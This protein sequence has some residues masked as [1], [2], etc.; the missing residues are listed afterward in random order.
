VK[1]LRRSF[2]AR[3]GGGIF[4]LIGTMLL[5]TGCT[6]PLWWHDPERGFIYHGWSVNIA[7][8]ATVVRQCAGAPNALGCVIP[9]TMTA[10]S[11]NNPYVL[12]HECAHIRNL[13]AG[14]GAGESIKDTA[15]ML[16]GLNDMLTMATLLLPAPNDCGDG[17]M[18]QWQ[19]GE[20]Q[21]VHREI[22]ATQ[23][24]PTLE[25]W[26][27]SQAGNVDRADRAR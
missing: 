19:A 20:L 11:V 9:D 18:A 16:L 5:L 1:Q 15:F 10:F 24:L 26:Q 7:D 17:T 6:S 25:Q 8:H 23:I 2:L 27:Q 22:G 13:M 3:P 14:D 21:V 4:V 12:A